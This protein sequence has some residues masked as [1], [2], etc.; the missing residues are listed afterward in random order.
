VWHHH[1]VVRDAWLWVVVID[2]ALFVVSLARILWERRWLGAIDRRFTAILAEHGS[3]I[4][5]VGA[6]DRDVVIGPAER[7]GYCRATSTG[8]TIERDGHTLR[9]PEGVP[10]SYR[11]RTPTIARGMLAIRGGTR[12]RAIVH[13]EGVGGG[14]GLFRTADVV[15]LDARLVLVPR[16]PGARDQLVTDRVSLAGVAAGF[17]A[18]ALEGVACSALDP[19]GAVFVG[20]LV[21]VALIGD[22]VLDNLFV[23]MLTER[24]A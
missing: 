15:S 8:F 13:D 9:V 6:P 4:T 10:I 5:I 7:V 20:I 19:G 24:A 21:T 23:R 11:H 18:L 16:E 1:V 3:D 22:H 2:T 14:E 12:L 17:G